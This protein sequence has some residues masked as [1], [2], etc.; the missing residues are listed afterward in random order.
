MHGLIAEIMSKSS[1]PSPGLDGLCFMHLKL[2]KHSDAV[3]EMPH[4]AGGYPSDRPTLIPHDLSQASLPTTTGRLL[5][6]ST[7]D[8]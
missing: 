8:R 5:L 4:F 1:T 6:T 7:S 3:I 2:L